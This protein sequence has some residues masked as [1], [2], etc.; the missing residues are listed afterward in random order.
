[1][2]RLNT[3]DTTWVKGWQP[4]FVGTLVF[5]RSA[6]EVLLIRKKTGHGAGKINGPGGKLAIGETAFECAVREVREE[7]GLELH[8][9]VCLAELRFVERNGPQWLGFAFVAE[10]FTGNPVETREAD[11]FWCAIDAIPY[12][13]MWPDD[14]IWLPRILAPDA[15]LEVSNYLFDDGKLL[16]HEF[17]DE[18]SVWDSLTL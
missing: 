8:D 1:M 15:C 5:V 14:A 16:H 3:F 18:T 4:E 7:V 2:A 10:T 12:D 6:G 13:D 11:P 9:P 17:V